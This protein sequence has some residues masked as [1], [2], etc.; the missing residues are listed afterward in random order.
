MKKP[1]I[2]VIGLGWSTAAFIKTINTDKYTV[3]VISL[4]DSFIYTPL[5]AKNIRNN[6]SLAIH[7]SDINNDILFHSSEVVD[8][9]FANNSVIT[10]NKDN[11]HYDYLIISHGSVTNTFGIEGVKDNCYFIKDDNQANALRNKIN[12]LANNSNIAVIGCGLTGTEIIGSLLDYRRFNIHAIDALPRAIT[13]FDNKLSNYTIRLW[14]TQNVRTYFNKKV[15]AIDKT[16]IYFTDNKELTYDL[17]IWCGGIKKAPLT[18][19]ILNSL[20]IENSKGIPIDSFMK[21]KT[22]TNLFAM[23]DCAYSGFPPTAQVAYQQGVFTG[24]YFNS[25]FKKNDLFEYKSKGQIAYIGLGKSVCQLP[26]LQ[27]GGNLVYYLNSLIHVYNGI[28]F[29]QRYALIFS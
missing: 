18:E 26:Y 28:N 3:K 23:G 12:T 13:T 21:V 11:I 24:K 8:I 9:D 29:K 22:T 4:N 17:A 15:S 6:K 10:I 5:L 27:S 19:K 7:G 25:D 2:V 16:K 20:K 14:E 1:I